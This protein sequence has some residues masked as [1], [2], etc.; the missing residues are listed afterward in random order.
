MKV[1]AEV[2][3]EQWGEKQRV[4]DDLLWKTNGTTEVSGNRGETRRSNEK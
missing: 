2:K 1:K 4:Q 3:K